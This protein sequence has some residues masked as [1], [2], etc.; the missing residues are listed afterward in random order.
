MFGYGKLL[1]EKD[2]RIA[3]LKE[4]VQYLR[5]LV[6][7][8]NDPYNTVETISEADQLLTGE[9][10]ELPDPTPETPAI[11]SERQLKE[12]AEAER[13]ALLSN[14]YTYNAIFQERAEKQ[15]S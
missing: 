7:P 14:N 4:Q 5:T 12:L 15:D 9:P 3:E 1:A 11:Y 2:A 6:Y 10:L 13:D 8:Q